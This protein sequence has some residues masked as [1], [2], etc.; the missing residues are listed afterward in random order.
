MY[1]LGDAVERYGGV[2]SEDDLGEAYRRF[3]NSF[4]GQLE[5]HFVVL[6]EGVQV[7][8][9]QPR[10]KPAEANKR[11]ADDAESSLSKSFKKPSY[12]K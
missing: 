12:K 9:P 7:R 11:K 3:G 2:V 6:K 10:G 8:P 1:T 5:Q 4:K